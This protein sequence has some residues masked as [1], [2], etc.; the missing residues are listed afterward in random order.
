GLRSV[1]LSYSTAHA[2]PTPE[3][4]GPFGPPQERVLYRPQTRAASAL[5]LG[6]AAAVGPAPARL[7]FDRTLRVDRF[8]HPDSSD[9]QTRD[10]VL[11]TAFADDFDGVTP[12]KEADGS[13]EVVELVVLDLGLLERDVDREMKEIRDQ[14]A[15]AR[16][17]QKQAREDARPVEQR[18]QAGQPLTEQ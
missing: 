10:R 4:P 9:L 13:K 15:A 8:K 7:E 6:G 11:F 5:L 1:W 18:L 12:G 3:R 16:D 14:V 17:L 2:G